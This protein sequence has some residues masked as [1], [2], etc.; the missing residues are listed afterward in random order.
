MKV[1]YLGS[2][3]TIGYCKLEVSTECNRVEGFLREYVAVGGGFQIDNDLP[4]DAPKQLRR[5]NSSVI[6]QIFEYLK[7]EQA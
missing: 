2:C 5:F 1:E 4:V 3:R 6:W 7:V